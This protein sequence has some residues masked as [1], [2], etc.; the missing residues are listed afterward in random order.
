[1]RGKPFPVSDEMRAIQRILAV[2]LLVPCAVLATDPDL[3]RQSELEHMLIHDCGSCHGMRLTGG[4]GPALTPAAMA[5]RPVEVIEQ[6]I[7]RG[8]PGTPMPPWSAVLNQEEIRW[9]ATRLRE[10]QAHD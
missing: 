6:V 9:L 7:T 10:G 4:L 8:V 5:T 2:A 1:M 3:S